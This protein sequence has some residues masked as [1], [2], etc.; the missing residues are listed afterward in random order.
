MA[1]FIINIIASAG[2]SGLLVAGLIWFSKTWMGERI[3][4]SIK[5]EYDQKLESH[6]ELL[7]AQNAVELERL[8]ADLG[9]AAVEHQVRFERLDERIAEV[10]TSIYAKL[11][12]VLLQH[13]R[14]AR[15]IEDTGQERDYTDTTRLK[16]RLS[17]FAEGVIDFEDYYFERG[18]FLDSGLLDKIESFMEYVTETSIGPI[19]FLS[20]EGATNWEL[21]ENER[22]KWLGSVSEVEDKLTP[23]IIEMRRQIRSILGLDDEL[24]TGTKKRAT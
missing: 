8:K 18:V 1:E 11:Q 14:L 6:K 9:K 10:I 7:K 13:Q 4:Q 16:D 23:I 3:K 22:K 20:L 21:F 2:V 12:R 5:S 15:I 19:D 17:S 24:G